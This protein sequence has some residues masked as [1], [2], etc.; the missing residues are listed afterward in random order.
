MIGPFIISF[1]NSGVR[2]LFFLKESPSEKLLEDYQLRFPKKD[3]G[4][5]DYA[6]GMLREASL[7]LR[8]IENYF[9]SFDLSQ[10]RFLIMLVLSNANDKKRLR[11]KDIV[12]QMDISKPIVSNTL[13]SMEAAGLVKITPDP[14]DGR[15]KIVQLKAKGS[16]LLEKVLPG[17]YD[18]V[19][20]FYVEEAEA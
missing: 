1:T 7:L 19:D 4:N 6:L 11:A 8:E 3:V 17:Y 15:S 10:T 14:N 16:K 12:E 9:Q 5:M 20:A 18:V 2:N 13:K